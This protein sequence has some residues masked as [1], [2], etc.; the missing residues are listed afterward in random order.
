MTSNS[1]PQKPDS[2]SR[3][4]AA[5]AR[6]RERR[7]FWND[8]T[9][10]IYR[11]PQDVIEEIGVRDERGELAEH[12]QSICR[13]HWIL[14]LRNE[15]WPIALLLLAGIFLYVRSLGGEFLV[16][17]AV[18]P[19][20]MDIVNRILLVLIIAIALVRL[21]LPL[22]A[23][24]MRQSRHGLVVTGIVLLG[25]F[26]FR[27]FLGGRLFVYTGT[28]V[29]NSFNIINNLLL[30][31]ILATVIVMI[32][33]FFD[34]LNDFLILTN[35][36]VI[37]D[38]EKLFV[39]RVQD[40]L[41]IEDVQSVRANTGTQSI[42]GYVQH[43]LK[44]GTIEVQSA[45]FREPIV[46]RTA[47]NPREMQQQIDAAV[48][49]LQKTKTQETYTRIVKKIMQNGDQPAAQPQ[50]TSGTVKTS[51]F[52]GRFLGENPEIADDGT[53]TWRPHEIFALIALSRPAGA[54]LLGLIVVYILRQI[55]LELIPPV[56]IVLILVVALIVFWVVW[57]YEDYRNDL[58]I[59]KPTQVIDVEKMP[60]GPENRRTAS[61]GA[62]QNV[63]LKTSFIGRLIGYGDV[64]LETAG[65]GPKSKLTFHGVPR[66]YEVVARINQY[67]A[68]F[69]RGEKERTLAET[70]AL[71][72]TFYKH[73]PDQ[74]HNG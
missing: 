34:W 10:L 60:F 2:K 35:K 45:S 32:Y 67:L 41:V 13:H 7:S 14:L 22:G 20:E 68:D 9:R 52:L 61:L 70:T 31:G 30:L 12:I 11:T 66:P 43:L 38:D 74:F 3:M 44:A 69:R 59:L 54:L 4:R 39:R 40:Q 65:G 47:Q 21:I 28:P 64:E 8:A 37:Y 27:Y 25:L 42:G 17:G 24:N 46:F 51:H 73:L 49:A 53:I 58:Y 57:I 71:L 48:K 29:V 55:G 18:D 19:G 50:K 36:R 16:L 63:Q 26:A 23:S 15:L 5:R 62:L 1:G 33:I 6:E 56:W 72:E